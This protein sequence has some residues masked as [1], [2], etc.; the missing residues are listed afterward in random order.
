MC[1]AGLHEVDTWIMAGTSSSTIFSYSG[2][3]YSSVS[4]GDV[5]HAPD[6]S[7]FRLQPTKP[8]SVT[9]RSSSSTLAFSGSLAT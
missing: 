3:Q 6:G 8:S 9:Q 5:H 2:N 1:T 7:G 4:G